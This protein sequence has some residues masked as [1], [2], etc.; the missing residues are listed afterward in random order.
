MAPRRARGSAAASAAVIVTAAGVGA[1]FGGRRHKAFVPLNGRPLLAW[2]LL[3]C[4][5]SLAVAEVVVTVHPD[6]KARAQALVRRFRCRKVRAIVPGGA[7]RA[8]S[9]ACGLAA[10]SPSTEIVA[11]H[12]AARPL[13]T[14]ALIARVIE[15]AAQDGAA[16][17][18]IP[19]VSTVKRVQDGR[20]VETVD[21]RSLWA[22]QTPQ[23][24]RR[25]VLADAYRTSKNAAAA[26]DEAMLVEQAGVR[27][28][29]VEDNSRNMKITTPD[30][31]RMAKALL[32]S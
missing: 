22:A 20:T 10:V 32:A 24:F 1:R 27:S 2:S 9:V 16:L 5:A 13:V 8:E 3:A 28:R 12:D 7:T 23:A 21:R 19:V 18:A 31:L 25:S 17:A 15:A 4:E 29:I 26:T 14:P 6:D 30:D 11:V